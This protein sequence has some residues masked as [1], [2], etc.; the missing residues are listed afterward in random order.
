MKPSLSVPLVQT[1]EHFSNM[2]R[3]DNLCWML[4]GSCGLVLHGV[5]L[6]SD[7]RDVD[8][9]ADEQDVLRLQRLWKPYASDE[10]EWNETERYRSLL[11]HY[12]YQAVSIELVGDFVVSTSLGK[13]VTGIRGLLWNY[14]LEMQLGQTFVHVMPLAHE[15]VF[16]VLRERKDRVQSIV[17]VMN[18]SPRLHV[19]SMRLV[20]AQCS[21]H[22][23]LTEVLVQLC[24]D[25]MS[26]ITH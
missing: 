7:P 24:P 2:A 4:G 9:Y 1:I 16:N 19:D 18:Q 14:G 15:L 11:S 6:E 20:W 22:A 3:G 17:G 10:P 23:R 5:Q 25:I 13:Y 8:I 26:H 21:E 12:E